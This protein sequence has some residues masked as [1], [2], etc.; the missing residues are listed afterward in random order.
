M[1]GVYISMLK[2]AAF[3]FEDV[4]FICLSTDTSYAPMFI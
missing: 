3:D 4:E 2:L 1:E